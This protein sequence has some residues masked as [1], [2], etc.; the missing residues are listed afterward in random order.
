M[1]REELA[2]LEHAAFIAGWKRG[3]RDAGEHDCRMFA[4][5]AERAWVE[6]RTDWHRQQDKVKRLQGDPR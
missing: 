4:P 6:W 5:T 1:T 3:Y 2:E